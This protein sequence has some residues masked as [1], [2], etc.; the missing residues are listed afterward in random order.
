M[1]C[2]RAKFQCLYEGTAFDADTSIF[3]AQKLANA[4][5]IGK[6]NS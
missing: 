2:K 1:G 3:A 5:V 4:S 6:E